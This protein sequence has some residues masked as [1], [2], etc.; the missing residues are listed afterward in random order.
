MTTREEE[1]AAEYLKTSLEFLERSALEFD[2]GDTLQACEKLWGAASHAVIAA[3]K[4]KGWSFNKHS[5]LRVAVRR[6]AEEMD[7][8][9][10]PARFSVAKKFHSNFYRDFMSD[11]EIESDRPIVERLVRR[12][13]DLVE[14]SPSN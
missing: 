6:L 14:A 7:D 5:H 10:L 4:Q 12:I 9:S 8:D 1:T 2:A 13:V 3:S 11:D